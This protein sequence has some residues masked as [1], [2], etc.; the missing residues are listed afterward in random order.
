MSGRRRE[1]LRI[2][3][4]EM[5][6]TA[7][8]QENEE[9]K[10]EMLKEAVGKYCE[11]LA[12][13]EN[14]DDDD[15]WAGLGGAYRRIGDISQAI[16]SYATACR[17]NDESTYALV[18][19][20]SLMAARRRPEDEHLL[21]H[22]AARAEQR[23]REKIASVSADHWTWYDMATL[24]LIQGKTSQS[25]ST[26]LYAVER[27]PKGARENFVSVLSNL[28]FL[29]KHNRGMPGLVEAI[30]LIGKYAESPQ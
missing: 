14:K 25:M 6:R 23:L 18:N 13:E 15:A 21:Q 27:T 22:Y 19:L 7:S 2:E 17:L 26:F 12:F 11:Y 24:E 8:K 1:Y 28:Q 20:V 5:V 30:S 10:R 4:L 29:A 16:E 3:A 9:A